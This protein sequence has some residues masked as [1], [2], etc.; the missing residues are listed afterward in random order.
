MNLSIDNQNMREMTDKIILNVDNEDVKNEV[1]CNLPVMT[2]SM[3][4]KQIEK[5]ISSLMKFPDGLEMLKKSWKIIINNSNRAENLIRI[6]GEDK[7]IRKEMVDNI[8]YFL[9]FA[10]V[11]DVSVLAEEFSK[12]EGGNEAISENFDE[13]FDETIRRFDCLVIPALQ[14]EIGRKKVK[15]RFE[16]IKNRILINI[17]EPSISSF[18]RIVKELENKP[19]FK[20][21]YEDYK[22]WVELYEDIEMFDDDLLK[23]VNSS[24]IVKVD[25]ISNLSVQELLEISEKTGIVFNVQDVFKLDTKNQEFTKILCSDDRH[26]KRMVL[27]AVANGNKFKFK[28]SGTSALTIQ[29]GNQVAKIG[30][31]KRKFEIPY[32]PRLLMPYFRKK[33]DDN[34]TLEVYNLGNTKSAKIND[35]MLLDIYKELERDGIIWTD[36]HKDNLLE[37]I[38]DNVVPDFIKSKD[39]NLF[40]FLKHPDYPTNNHEVLKA[41]DIIICDLDMVYLKDDPEIKIG[42]LDDKIKE[43]R[44]NKKKTIESEKEDNREI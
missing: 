42:L 37:L 3:D 21:I 30:S 33:Y 35:E 29:A 39:F 17:Y 27:E 36:A 8:Q 44:N 11:I 2:L 31:N 16:E 23:K 6:L 13:L 15:E 4:S 28:S 25:S 24:G 43:Y 20:E 41:G 12:F 7:T 1:I 40:G 22:F 19:E 38:S 5:I 34:T 26:E 10:N 32:H 9:K 18:F 14:T